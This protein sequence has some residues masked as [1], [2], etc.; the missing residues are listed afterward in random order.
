[1]TSPEQLLA[2]LDELG[3]SAKTHTHPALF[4]VEDSKALRGDLPGQHCKN[5]FLKDKKKALWLIV[6]AEDTP[7][8][9]KELKGKIGSHH[10]SF[11][12]PDLLMEVL[13]VAPGSVTPFALINDSQQQVNVILDSH[14]MEAELVNYHPLSNEMT[15]ALT[16]DGLREFI[17]AC[18]H[19]LREV[20]L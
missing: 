9:L 10:L 13:G 18:G 14:M 8:N 5:L 16:P 17:K 11:A 15:T 12:K 3:I 20:V 1:M 2:R 7:I 4:T 6:A 19:E